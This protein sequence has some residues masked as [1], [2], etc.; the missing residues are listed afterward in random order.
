[1]KI[2]FIIKLLKGD[3]PPLQNEDW[4]YMILLLYYLKGTLQHYEITIGKDTVGVSLLAQHVPTTCCT[5]R[6]T[7]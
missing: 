2:G 3:T 6:A 1:M 5:S 7:K 4:F